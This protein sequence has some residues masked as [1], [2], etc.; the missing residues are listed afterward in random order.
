MFSTVRYFIKTSTLFLTVGIVTGFYTSFSKHVFNEGDS[1]EM[2]S[3]PHSL[4]PRQ[5]GNDDNY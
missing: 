2:A 4:Y 3:S 1:P 5:P